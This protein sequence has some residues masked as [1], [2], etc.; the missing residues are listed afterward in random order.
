MMN[1]Y[2]ALF[3]VVW[4]TMGVSGLLV[5]AIYR[6]YPKAV[7]AYHEGLSTGQWALAGAFCIGMA[8][9]EAYRGFQLRFSPRTAARIRYLREQP[10]VVRSLLAPLFAMGFFHATKRTRITAFALTTG[11]VILV[12]SVQQLAQP[13]RGII[14]A[15]VV[16][17]LSWGVLSLVWFTG[18]A[19]IR[20]DYEVSPEV[21]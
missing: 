14:D 12:V 21:P 18:K 7:T 3:G 19:L 13:W 6:L 8:Y 20:A 15:G 1:R 11:I 16:I 4:A 2:I 10:N 9:A 5:F 17:G